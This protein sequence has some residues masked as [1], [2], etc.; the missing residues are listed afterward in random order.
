M[1][2]DNTNTTTYFTHDDALKLAGELAVPQGS[3]GRYRDTLTSYTPEEIEVFN[4]AMERHK[5][6]DPVD[7]ILLV[8][9]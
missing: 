8:E 3:W 1:S 5:V 4:E 6:I 9:G 2:S 7:F